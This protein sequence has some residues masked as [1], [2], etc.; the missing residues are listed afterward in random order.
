MK[1]LIGN[2]RRLWEKNNEY[3]KDSTQ[4]EAFKKW[5]QGSKVVDENGTPLVVYHGSPVGNITEFKSD[6]K[7][8]SSKWLADGGSGAI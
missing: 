1:K 8:G 7:V 3:K 2:P 4:S 6:A 5:F